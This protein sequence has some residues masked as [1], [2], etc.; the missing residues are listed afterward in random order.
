MAMAITGAPPVSPNAQAQTA[1]TNNITGNTIT[2]WTVP[3]NWNPNGTP[4]YQISTATG[5]SN[6]TVVVN[7]LAGGNVTRTPQLD[8][9]GE[10]FVFRTLTLSEGATGN[11]D[12]NILNTGGFGGNFSTTQELERIEYLVGGRQIDVYPGVTFMDRSDGRAFELAM[13][14]STLD[15][16]GGIVGSEGLIVSGGQALYVRGYAMSY[17]IDPTNGLTFTG[18]SGGS[19]ISTS[20]QRTGQSPTTF[21]I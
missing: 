5:D 20:M 9:D 10:S 18:G 1:F 13:G 11:A 4:G 2:F 3:F 8:F 16:G 21:R 7:F 19:K 12:G 14:G 6:D 15:L 17:G